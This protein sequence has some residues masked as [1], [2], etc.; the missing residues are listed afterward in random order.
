MKEIKPIAVFRSPLTS[1]FG[2]PRQSGIVGNIMGTIELLPP[3]NK[4]EAIRGIENFDYL[5]LIWGFSANKPVK[6]VIK[7]SVKLTVRPPR[8]GGNGRVGVFAS[9]SPF[10]PNGLGLSSVK[11]VEVKESSIDVRGADLMNGTPIY[12]IKPYLSYVDSHIEARGGFTDEYKWNVLRVDIDKEWGMKFDNKKM[13]MLREIL[14]QDPRPQYHH[15]D[16]RVY[17]MSFDGKDIRFK[18]SNGVLT[19]CD[20]VETIKRK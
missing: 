13:E 8:L 9:R 11:I 17:G 3:Y 1:K 2:I 12:D 15:D 7:E 6:K 19:V 10:R 16:N 14:K 20:V 5:W 18:V 4:K